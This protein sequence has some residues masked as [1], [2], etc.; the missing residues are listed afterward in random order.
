MKDTQNC[1]FC[2]CI[3]CNRFMSNAHEVRITGT[4]LPDHAFRAHTVKSLCGE[5]FQDIAHGKCIGVIIQDFLTGQECRKITENFM[6]SPEVKDRGDGVAGKS[7]GADLYKAMPSEYLEKT[8]QQRRAVSE[9]FQDTVNVPLKLRETIQRI[10]PQGS[11]VR[12]ACAFGI[13]FNHVRAVRWTDNG[14]HALKFHDD[15][16]QLM[17]PGQAALETSRVQ[18]PVAFNVYP[19]VSETG[20]GLEVYNIAPDD[21]SRAAL[22]VSCTGYPYPLELL[23]GRFAKL[24]IMP[25]AGDLVILSGRFVHGV[26]GIGGQLPRILLNHFGGHIDPTTFVTWS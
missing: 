13:E 15:Q 22:G 3:G 16:A 21:A 20:G 23:E 25:K 26:Q 1:C 2:G 5:T 4:S 8:Q 9:L 19:S 6:N 11:V 24:T 17:D 14:T 10:M 7:I 18:W 12:P